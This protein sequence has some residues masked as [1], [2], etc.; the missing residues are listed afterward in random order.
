[1]VGNPPKFFG[2]I[3]KFYKIGILLKQMGIPCIGN[4]PKK[5]NKLFIFN[6]EEYLN[7]VY[8]KLNFRVIIEKKSE[9]F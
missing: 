7:L 8:F 5:Y 1:M 9:K 4:L 6:R 3:K 2:K